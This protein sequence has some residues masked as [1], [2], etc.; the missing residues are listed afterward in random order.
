MGTTSIAR[1]KSLPAEERNRVPSN[2]LSEGRL[3]NRS[4]PLGGRASSKRRAR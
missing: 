1:L 3:R 4:L 2:R